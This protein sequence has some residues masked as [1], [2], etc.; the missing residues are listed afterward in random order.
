MN[1]NRLTADVD[2]YGLENSVK[3][4]DVTLKKRIDTMWE[5]GLIEESRNLAQLDISAQHPIWTAIG[6]FEALAFLRNELSE[7][8]QKKKYSV[9]HGN[10]LSVN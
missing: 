7:K 10:T 5:N 6:Y 2:F 3:N 8:R 4:L 1:L 9:E